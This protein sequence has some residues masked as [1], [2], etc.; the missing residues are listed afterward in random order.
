MEGGE[1]VS[2]GVCLLGGSALPLPVN[3]QTI[4]KKVCR[5]RTAHLLPISPSMH[6]AEWVLARGGGFLLPGGVC[7][8]WGLF[9]GRGGLLP[10]GVC[11]GSVCV[12]QHALRQTP[13]PRE[14][15]D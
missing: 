6:C 7:A 14:Q 1:S 12:S 8:Q 3:R 9:P 4:L 11:L 5:M 15:N 10:G 13:N 2:G